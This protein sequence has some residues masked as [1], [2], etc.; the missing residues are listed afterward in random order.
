MTTQEKNKLIA[1]S[2]GIEVIQ[3]KY[4]LHLPNDGH[5]NWGNEYDPSTNMNQLIEAIDILCHK[6]CSGLYPCVW[7]NH[8]S[9]QHNH[10]KMYSNAG[11]KEV[12]YNALI[13]YLEKLTEKK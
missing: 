7:I 8:I 12:Y 4:G 6:S 3:R 5:G 13:N 1:D 10:D 9:E 11:I 2:C